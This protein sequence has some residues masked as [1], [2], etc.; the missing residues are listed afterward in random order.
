MVGGGHL[1]ARLFLSYASSD[2]E[3]VERLATSLTML[4][5]VVWL[6]RWEITVGEVLP[7]KIAAG[8][9][10]TDYVVVVLSP[11]ALQS[12]WVER[13]IQMAVF[14]EIGHQ[15]TRVLP[16][17]IA[18][19]A[20]PPLLRAKFLADFRRGYEVGLVQL[21]IALHTA[22]DIQPRTLLSSPHDQSGFLLSPLSSPDATAYTDGMDYHVPRFNELTIELG[23]PYIG[24]IAGKWKPDAQEQR[25]A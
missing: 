18:D 5:H 9:A 6:D 24:K 21:G 20:I 3:F 23:L 12:V 1:M 2:C 19:C 16:V 13:E 14:D 8:L 10:A 4:G 7:G 22:R 11:A 25:A 15:Q 17:V